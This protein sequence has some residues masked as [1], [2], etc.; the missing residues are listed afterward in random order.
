MNVLVVGNGGRESALA[1]RIGRDA[2]VFA[3]MQHPNPTIVDLCERTQGRFAIGDYRDPETVAG[4]ARAWKI[5][6]A[7]VQ[8]DDALAA[9]VVDRLQAEA[10]LAVG[11]TQA[12]AE[13]EWNKAFARDLLHSLAPAWSPQYWIVQDAGDL[14]RVF[15]EIRAQ[16][17]E[18]VVKPQGLTGGKGV[19]VMGPH[20]ADYDAAQSYA[21]DI[22]RE[23]TPSSRAVVL[24][25]KMQGIEF[26]LQVLTDGRSVV[27]I[28]ASYDY[29]FREAGDLGPGTGGMGS[30]TCADGLLPFLRREEYAA[31]LRLADQVVNELNALGRHFNGVL[32]VGFFL[33]NAGIKV[34]EFNARVGDPEGMNLMLALAPDVSVSRL[35][36]EIAFGKL[37]E[38]SV[39]FRS[40]ATV[41]KYLVSPEYCY[42][43][44]Q[45]HFFSL[46]VAEIQ[47]AGGHVFF[48]S[49]QRKNDGYV[50]VGASRSVA[51]A[52]VAPALSAASVSIEECI[53]KHLR[54]GLHHRPDVA[55]TS[56]MARLARLEADLRKSAGA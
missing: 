39:R 46:D 8:N 50:T 25:E 11:P 49:A 31:C 7:V 14:T 40:E 48:S 38:G 52:A 10:F 15:A 22:L 23:G 27:H 45:E 30:F 51:V 2:S 17:L 54:G 1:W 33:T 18:I 16:D 41:V 37:R 44:P 13:I 12:G 47:A 35:L 6:L 36:Q 20:L 3:V 56:Y 42:P 34:T 43:C 4:Y 29:P 19:K 53:E 5:D 24:E 32:N 26:T 21:E 9:G 28:P 55:S